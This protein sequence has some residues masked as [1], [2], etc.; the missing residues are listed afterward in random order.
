MTSLRSLASLPLFG[1]RSGAG[2]VAWSLMSSFSCS[3]VE[4]LHRVGGEL[5]HTSRVTVD[6]VGGGVRARDAGGDADAV[7]GRAAHGEPG[8]ARQ[9]LADAGHAGVVAD[10]VLGQTVL[11]ARDAGG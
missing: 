5:L 2:V 1:I 3:A 6:L 9:V 7:V 8:Q 10:G 4:A 11:P